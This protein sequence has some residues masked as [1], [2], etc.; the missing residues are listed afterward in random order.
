M[1][2]LNTN[3]FSSQLS[4][5]ASESILYQIKSLNL[6]SK[7]TASLVNSVSF[8]VRK[9][10]LDKLLLNSR[11][12]DFSADVVKHA[13]FELRNNIFLFYKRV[14]LID[15]NNI[16]PG[17]N[18]KFTKSKS[19]TY[20]EFRFAG[21]SND[22]G[23]WYIHELDVEN[24]I[25]L[26]YTKQQLTDSIKDGSFKHLKIDIL[27]D[28]TNN[29]GPLRNVNDSYVKYKKKTGTYNIAR[30]PN[31]YDKK[32]VYQNVMSDELKEL[33][34]N[35]S[36]FWTKYRLHSVKTENM[37]DFKFLM[38]GNEFTPIIDMVTKM[39]INVV[40]E[41]FFNS[42]VETLINSEE[43]SFY[44][45]HIKVFDNAS[46][47]K[48]D[49]EPSSYLRSQLIKNSKSIL[50]ELL[51]CVVLSDDTHKKIHRLNYSDGM[52]Y[53]DKNNKP[54]ALPWGISNKKNFNALK[55]R[56]KVLKDVDYESLYNELFFTIDEMIEIKEKLKLDI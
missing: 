3:S 26:N 12:I 51:K 42:V 22:S 45:H 55:K 4:Q 14:H 53:M 43:S 56:F 35:V 34:E 28:Y 15:S 20:I 1:L 10:F 8:S 17:T 49:V 5:I 30:S 31:W 21:E 52:L 36:S 50:L 44:I 40:P 38:Y 11:K 48:E 46:V 27:F 29:T 54:Y 23:N 33:L 13:D 47:H 25:S 2:V 32:L 16:L 18:K 37:R 24:F 39:P 7:N 9:T 19:G 41:L 6:N